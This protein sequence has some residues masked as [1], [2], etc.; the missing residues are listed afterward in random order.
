M[1]PNN[2]YI[3]PQLRTKTFIFLTESPGK[4]PKF[5]LISWCGIF[6]ER[7]NFRRDSAESPKTLK[8][9]CFSTKFPH[10]EIRWNFGILRSTTLNSVAKSS[11][12]IVYRSRYISKMFICV[13]VFR[14]LDWSSVLVLEVTNHVLMVLVS[15]VLKIKLLADRI[16]VAMVSVVLKI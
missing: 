9:L 4:V 12:D 6:V 2:I 13:S 7:L 14:S 11:R 8:T 10:Q 3:L 15:V 5:H 16:L 1:L